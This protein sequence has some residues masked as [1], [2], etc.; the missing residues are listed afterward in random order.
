MPLLAQVTLLALLAQVVGD[1]ASVTPESCAPKRAH[2]LRRRGRYRADGGV[3]RYAPPLLWTVPGSGN[4]MMR[5]LLEFATLVRTGSVQH[6]SR[7]IASGLLGEG[8][9]NHDVVVVKVHRTA[10]SP[11]PPV[12][13]QKNKRAGVEPMAWKGLAVT[14]AIAIVRD[15]FNAYFAQYQLKHTAFGSHASRLE[16]AK[17]QPADFAK[18]ALR[19]AQLWNRT[20]FEYD[21]FSRMRCFDRVRRVPDLGQQLDDNCRLGVWRFEAL[22][23]KAERMRTF[24]QIVGFLKL[25]PELVPNRAQVQCAFTLTD[26]AGDKIRRS[27]DDGNGRY[28]TRE[29]AFSSAERARPGVLCAFWAIVREHAVRLGYAPYKNMTHSLRRAAE[30]V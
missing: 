4:T 6:D 14:A 29:V 20:L 22:T 30:A 12:H 28:L 3:R 25:P 10:F 24:T 27:H 23:N 17:F 8:R 5:Q 18:D 9:V 1:T 7:L 21:D 19:F 13:L 15:P 11:E 16:T 2:F 26:V